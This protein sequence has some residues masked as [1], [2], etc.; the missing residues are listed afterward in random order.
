MSAKNRLLLARNPD[1]SPQD[2]PRAM[3]RHVRLKAIFTYTLL[4]LVATLLLAGCAPLVQSEQPKLT[5]FLPLE[6]GKSVGQTFS[7]RYDGLQ[8][9]AVYLKPL[10]PGTGS[11]QATLYH[12]PFKQDA[13]AQTSL[14]L[15]QVQGKSYYRFKFPPQADSALKDYYLHLELSGEGS[16]QVGIAPADSYLNG[17]AYRNDQPTEAQ[18]ALRLV[19]APRQAALG[20]L[21]ETLSWLGFL[22]AGA[23]LY[24]LPGWGMLAW[25]YPAWGRRGW[26]EKLGL[27]CSASL[28]IY[29]LLYLYTDLIGL[30]LGQ[31]YTW[32]PPTMAALYLLLR[33]VL[34]RQTEPAPLV[35]D[36][37][38]CPPS[39]AADLAFVA[40][41]LLVILS[42]FWSVRTLAIPMW[43]DSYH[44][45]LVTQLLVNHG[46]LFN[47]WA[48]Y[49]EMTTFTYHFGFHSLAAGL[50][51][52]TGLGAPAAVLWT[53]QIVNL[54]AVLCLY[55]LAT[56]LGHNPW[57]GVTAVLLAGL[58]APMPMYYV[59]WG[60][61]TQLAG[62][63]IL[64]SGVYLMWETLTA[65][66]AGW[67]LPVLTALLLA[68]LALTH[69]RVVILAGLFLAA[70]WLIY[71][72]RGSAA[73]IFRRSLGFSLLA[74]LL[75]LPWFLRVFSGNLI[76]IF[77]ATLSGTPASTAQN[78]SSQVAK[79]IQATTGAIGNLFDY[80]PALIWLFL[81]PVIGWGLWRRERD[82]LLIA[83]WWWLAW[84]FGEP[85][86]YGLPG[87]GAITA[88]AVLIAAYIPAAL[89]F[90][91]GAGWA[92]AALP[93]A[94]PEE[95]TGSSQSFKL[96]PRRR[97][98]KL[99][100]PMLA[101][102][103]ICLGLWGVGLRL[104]DVDI[105]DHAL[106]LPPD[107]RA[108]AWITD[109]TP[110]AARFLVNA[111]PAFYETTV[112]GT[113]GGWWLPFLAGR[114]TTIPPMNYSFEQ[115]PWSGY[116]QWINSLYQEIE[117]NGI[118]HP[119]VIAEL[120][121]RGVT[122]VYIGQQQGSVSH[123]GP[124]NFDLQALQA[125]P[126]YRL[127]YRQ[128]R[129]WIFEV[130]PQ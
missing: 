100:Q 68:G 33:R 43:G 75:F 84:F 14:A 96:T 16:Y 15:D 60:R 59:N 35:D 116:Q 117:A 107:L 61:Y 47:S 54:L 27:A 48:P 88:F 1:F 121:R 114:Q 124:A 8:S 28:A 24:L 90:G 22:A 109:N 45:T 81:P 111:Q 103:A 58:L 12:D 105:P 87:S 38:A 51:D 39:L 11:I 104:A 82:A 18:L 94:P 122:H 78:V 23:V 7:A 62:Q 99:A 85:A 95:Q 56:R 98:G 41:M 31:I 42:R 118:D 128:D 74:M 20:L 6:P 29:P 110:E 130:L 44:H 112:V 71:L 127:V 37:S 102:A 106:V 115:E 52:L 83:V 119:A 76:D 70:F 55:P 64:V 89:L 53:G 13:L 36:K 32:L 120:R 19:Y 67:R 40:V 57:A 26:V 65:R 72:R 69:L 46:G 50:H 3:N 4:T 80:L 17:S 10:T 129:V 30:H 92:L 101:L 79:E 49:A 93:V 66:Q 123:F 108:F 125:S 91:A 126:H 34:R 21:R 77:T 86:W 25:L 9:V 113:D 97:W 73:M 63:V 5:A 2:H